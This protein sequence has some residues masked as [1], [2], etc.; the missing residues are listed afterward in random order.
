LHYLET[1]AIIYIEISIDLKIPCPTE[2]ELN[3]DQLVQPMNMV[4][5]TTSTNTFTINTPFYEDYKYLEGEHGWLIVAF[6]GVTTPL[7]ARDIVDLKI[8]T[9][10]ADGEI[11][12]EYTSTST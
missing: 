12:D 7:S 11:V 4:C 6:E 8:E 9:R 2:Y 3:S 5:E 1:S 10:M